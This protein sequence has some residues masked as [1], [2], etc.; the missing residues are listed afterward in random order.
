VEE[1][2]VSSII[3]IAIVIVI[4]VIAIGG[5]LLLRG[6][7]TRI[8]DIGNNPSKYMGKQVELKGTVTR[9][10]TTGGGIQIWVGVLNDV[11]GNIYLIHLPD[12]FFPTGASYLVKGIVEN[13]TIYS[14]GAVLAIDV[15]N[16]E[17]A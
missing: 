4:A 9:F 14:L 16:I 7:T 11:S 13:S 3:V 10:Q 12:N 17:S 2:G 5:Y 15:K 8:A 1:K 6:G